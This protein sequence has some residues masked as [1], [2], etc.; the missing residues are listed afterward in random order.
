MIRYS[1][2][3]VEVAVMLK[4]KDENKYLTKTKNYRINRYTE[5]KLEVLGIFIIISTV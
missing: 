2:N 1:G 5:T 3:A 4:G